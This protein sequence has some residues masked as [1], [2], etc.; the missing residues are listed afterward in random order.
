MHRRDFLLVSLAL[1]VAMSP[2]AS[3]PVGSPEGGAQTMN[4]EQFVSAMR[5]LVRHAGK[6]QASAQT[7]GEAGLQLMQRLDVDGPEFTSALE[8]SWESGNSFWLWQRLLRER[9]LLGGVLNIEQGNDVPLHDHPGATGM[10]R[11]LSGE[12]EVWQY[13]VVSDGDAEAG[14]VLR[15]V[16]H[17]ILRPGDTAVLYPELG[18]IH[19]LRA[20]SAECRMLDCFV[21]PYAR[22]MRSWY[23]PEAVDW[24]VRER[25]QCR[26][27]P[28]Q[29]FYA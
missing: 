12:A 13:D 21:P 18:N 24:R 9:G 8:Q 2:A 3:E 25:I 19:A 4:W 7:L 15:R 27:I 28:E 14:A 5:S 6:G 29:E 26:R 1:T 23:E 11:I 16:S 22:A 17:H 10:L 20:L